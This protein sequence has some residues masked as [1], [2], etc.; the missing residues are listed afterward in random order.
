MNRN[1]VI[2][3]LDDVLAWDLPEDATADALTTQAC[4]LAGVCPEE[5]E[6]SCL[7]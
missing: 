3:A 2:D 4:L 7:D 5:L 6:V 1:F